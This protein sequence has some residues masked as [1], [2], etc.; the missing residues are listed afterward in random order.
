MEVGYFLNES[1][2]V[3][4]LSS[5]ENK[6][7]FQNLLSEMRKY[8]DFD[9]NLETLEVKHALKF[10]TAKGEDVISAKVLD[11]KVN[12]HVNIRYIERFING[13]ESTTN[14]FFVGTI[15]SNKSDDP[16]VI[17]QMVFRA[18]N[19]EAV[20]ILEK[21]YDRELVVAAM[22][23]DDKFFEEFNFDENYVPGQLLKQK[24]DAQAPIKGCVAGGYIWCGAD[25][26]GWPACEGSKSGINEL[27]NCCKKHDCCYHTY[28]TS[29]SHC[30]CDQKLCDCAQAAPF[31][32]ATLLVEAAFCFVC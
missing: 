4:L 9:F 31:Y 29:G 16:N 30:Y 13:D 18:S 14:D 22:E 2:V 15:F 6:K 8:G 10:D 26:G 24:V 32:G 17:N 20:S 12:D 23:N 1:E 11:I 28:G 21:E 7:K 3:D 19:D 27:D 5:F 25:C